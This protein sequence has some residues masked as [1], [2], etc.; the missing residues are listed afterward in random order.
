MESFRE[1]QE[2]LEVYSGENR[3]YVS[4]DA[5]TFKSKYR[6]SYFMRQQLVA[7]TTSKVWVQDSRVQAVV[8]QISGGNVKMYY[9]WQAILRSKIGTVLHANELTIHFKNK[10]P[11]KLKWGRNLMV[12]PNIYLQDGN[13]IMVHE[14][15]SNDI[16]N[17]D[18]D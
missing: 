9:I 14:G 6:F 1:D 17:G 3:Y 18:V 8:I 10:M 11:W 15:S 16:S 5:C 4:Q 12:W 2:T 13:W 7:Y